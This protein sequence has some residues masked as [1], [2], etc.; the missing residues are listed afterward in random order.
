MASLVVGNVTYSATLGRVFRN[1]WSDTLFQNVTGDESNRMITAV[2]TPT[3]GSVAL[4]PLS[5]LIVYTPDD[6]YT[7]TDTFNF[8]VRATTSGGTTMTDTGTC[9][10]NV[11]EFDGIYP[12]ANDTE[13]FYQPVLSVHTEMRYN[14]E[15]NRIKTTDASNYTNDYKWTE[16][17]HRVLVLA[18]NSETTIDLGGVLEVAYL[19][20]ETDNDI[21]VSSNTALAYWPVSDLLALS[22][23]N[24]RTVIIKN[25]ST[26]NT[27][28]VRVTACD[29]V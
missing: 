22:R 17:A 5:G 8:T 13:S 23:T 14:I 2:T 25:E 7:G 28:T 26:T 11:S 6:T 24:C 15:R 20:I 27:A 4:S 19:F 12:Y 1:S 3:Y 16:S 9:T 29:E 10:I 21:K 18:T